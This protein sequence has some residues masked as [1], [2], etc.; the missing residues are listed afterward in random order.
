[1]SVNLLQE[2]GRSSLQAVKNQ[3]SEILSEQHVCCS[4]YAGPYNLLAYTKE[5]VC[6]GPYQGQC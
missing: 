2:G 1:M 4:S 6:A 3:T 5:T